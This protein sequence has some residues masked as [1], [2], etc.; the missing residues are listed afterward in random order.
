V[1][2]S[3]ACTTITV[4]GGYQSRPAILRPSVFS[5][6]LLCHANREDTI[7]THCEVL[8]ATQLLLFSVSSVSLWCH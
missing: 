1:V 2:V 8:M 5:V 4:R 3:R 7:H 6:S